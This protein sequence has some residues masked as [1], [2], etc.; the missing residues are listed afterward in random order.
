VAYTIHNIPIPSRSPDSLRRV[1]E[2][3]GNLLN[4]RSSLFTQLF[5]PRRDIDD[6]CGYPRSEAGSGIGSISVELY[7]NLY[8]R[9]AI[10]TRV[11]HVLPKESWQVTPYVFE[12]DDPDTNTPFE[13]AWDDL[14]RSLFGTGGKSWYQDEQGSQIW[15][16]LKRADILSGIG[17]FGVILLGID[18][19]LPLDQPV[20]GVVS[21]DQESPSLNATSSN[22]HPSLGSNVSLPAP[23]PGLRQTTRSTWGPKGWE[24]EVVNTSGEYSVEEQRIKDRFNTWNEY[25]HNV[26]RKPRG[27][28]YDGNGRRTAPADV[29]YHHSSTDPTTRLLFLRSFDESQVQ[30]VQ[31]EANVR[32]PRWGQP[33]MYRITLNDS[34][35]SHSGIGLPNASIRVHWSRVIH[36]ADNLGSSEIFGVPR[37]RPVLNR[38]LD[39]RK[40][41]SGSAEMYWRGAFPGI[42]LE[43]NPLHRPAY[44]DG[45]LTRAER[46]FGRV[47]GRRVELGGR[48]VCYRSPAYPSPRG[49]RHRPGR[50]HHD[51]PRLPHR[52]PRHGGG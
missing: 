22:G 3:V 12:S 34:R 45:C 48:E 16:H 37:M 38:L 47:A 32:N 4:L 2:M 43:T 17:H 18:D 15:E 44:T 24:T 26:I 27:T 31:Y 29:G 46:V 41:Y 51:S 14:S 25:V 1:E 39:L 5:D 28:T 49:I 52:D 33:I 19:G 11:V 42:S 36:L 10:S 20:E 8:E 9:E 30:V 35:E 23:W 7:R 6:E 40:L 21:L 50:V 13:E